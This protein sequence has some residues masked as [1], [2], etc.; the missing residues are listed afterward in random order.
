MDLDNKQKS[1]KIKKI[2]ETLMTNDYQFLEI[3]YKYVE[4]KDLE[5]SKEINFDSLK[6]VI[7]EISIKFSYDIEGVIDLISSKHT[8][9]SGYSYPMIKE[10]LLDWL[11]SQ[12]KSLNNVV[13]IDRK[14]FSNENNNSNRLDTLSKL[15][16]D[17]TNKEDLNNEYGKEFNFSDETDINVIILHRSLYLLKRKFEEH[18][19][20]IKET[21]KKYSDKNEKINIVEMS[22]FYLV[23]ES[24][25]KVADISFTEISRPSELLK[26]EVLEKLNQDKVILILKELKKYYEKNSSKYEDLLNKKKNELNAK[27]ETIDNE[28]SKDKINKENSIDNKEIDKNIVDKNIK[29]DNKSSKNNSN[30]D[31]KK[32]DNSSKNE[33]SVKKDN[34][35]NKNKKDKTN[36]TNSKDQTNNKSVDI[37]EKD[38]KNDK[39]SKNDK[40]ITEK[41]KD[42]SI[43]KD[44]SKKESD[45][46]KSN[47]EIKDNSIKKENELEKEKEMEKN[48]NNKSID[49][50]ENLNLSDNRINNTLINAPTDNE[51]NIADQIKMDF[52]YIDILPVLIADFLQDYPGIVLVDKSNELR[53]EM[54]ALFDNEI[55]HKLGDL[56]KNDLQEE[57]INKTK[58]LLFE[59]M[60]VERN[61]DLYEDLLIKNKAVGR[62]TIFI[63]GMLQKLKMQKMYLEKKIKEYQE[64]DVEDVK[65]N[66]NRISKDRMEENNRKASHENSRD[67]KDRDR[68]R[69]RERSPIRMEPCK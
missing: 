55:L 11:I 22:N 23:V 45:K 33:E 15:K 31:N 64:E 6:K 66:Y 68:L 38:S 2:K 28:I 36:N 67:D 52:I 8:Y 37:K 1:I 62:N 69:D 43:K 30:K 21:Y 19:V 3:F 42:K 59:K 53:N 63:E 39:N 40:K 27:K 49:E 54:K 46:I 25:M 34:S 58:E 5:S 41:E 57:K 16:N 51:K 29:E 47:S 10:N 61:L 9:V 65:E 26:I 14:N 20:K 32:K 50:K 18:D 48:N 24:V 60:N 44:D 35:D 4:M 7:A 12:E 17:L 56:A 13:N